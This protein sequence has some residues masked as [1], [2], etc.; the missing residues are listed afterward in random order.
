VFITINQQAAQRF[1]LR[2]SGRQT[3]DLPLAVTAARNGEIG[4]ALPGAITP[5]ALGINADTRT[6]AI[7]LEGIEFY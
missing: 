5:H 1:L 7:G 4:F 3:L 6:L 2:T